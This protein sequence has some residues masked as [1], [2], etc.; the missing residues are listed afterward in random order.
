MHTIIL[1]IDT[2]FNA[3]QLAGF[4][5]TLPYIKSVVT[6]QALNNSV[7]LSATDWVRPG[8]PAKDEEMEKLALEMEKEK[9]GLTTG[10]LKAKL[11]QWQKI[12]N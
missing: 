2:A 8:R 9:G 7:E 5:K 4:L 3:K 10:G 1:E 11:M 6:Q 12:E